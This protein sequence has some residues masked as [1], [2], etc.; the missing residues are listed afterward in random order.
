MARLNKLIPGEYYHV[1]NRGTN[2]M[3]IFLD[4]SDYK[5][6]QKLLYLVNS[7]LTGK[8]SNISKSKGS[9]WEYDRGES[10]VDIGAYCLMP[11]H[12]HL[13]IKIK[14]EEKASIFFQ[15]LQLSYSKYFNIKKDRNGVLFQGKI[16]ARRIT[17]NNDL[18]Y[19]FSYI[20]LNPI[21]LI[22]KDW[23]EKGIKNINEAKKFL[24]RYYYSSYCDFAREKNRDESKIIEISS[25]PNYFLS[26][27]VF[28]KEICDW[29]KI[30]KL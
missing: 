5:R 10:L 13:L 26:S 14:E 28:I 19:N 3:T 2:K 7:Q 12:F 22:Q 29:L 18:K 9:I 8:F 24:D 11:N 21:K 25:F 6:F 4:N 16:K 20:H 15:R 17:N 23:K 27:K 30:K 1:Y